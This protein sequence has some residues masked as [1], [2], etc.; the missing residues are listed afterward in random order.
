MRKSL[1]HL[2]QAGSDATVIPSRFEPCGLTQLCAMRY[3]SVPVV[4][5]VGGLADTIID[6]NE[7]A[8]QSG[9]ATGIQFAPVAA[10]ALAGALRRCSAFFAQKALWRRLQT[11]G[12]RTDVSW[13]HPA[14]RYAQIYREIAP[15]DS[16]APPIGQVASRRQSGQQ[17]GASGRAAEAPLLTALALLPGS[18]EPLGLTL[19]DDGANI[20]V[21]SE[22][23]GKNRTLPVRRDRRVRDRAADL[24]RA[25]GSG[26]SWFRSRPSGRR[27]L[28]LAGA[29]TLAPRARAFVSTPTSCCSTPMRWLSTDRSSCTTRCS[30]CAGR[31]RLA[32]R[33]RALRAEGRGDQ[34]ADRAARAAENS[35]VADH[36][37]TNCMCAALPAASQSLPED[38]ARDLRRSGPSRRVAHLKLSRRDDARNHALRGLD[39]RAAFACGGS[40]PIIGVIIP[41]R[42][43][44]PIHV[45]RP[46]A[47]ARCAIASPLCRPPASR[48]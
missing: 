47:G 11:N 43:W 12:L 8:L 36:S 23:G 29:R 6:A 10:E 18:P 26:L 41:L 48:C 37:S 1:A 28:W 14:C 42:L 34:P 31:L 22:G 35:V 5:R 24:T 7:M 30:G 9:C 25:D 4:A 17:S 21:Y 38:G 15:A 44:R 33:Q 27:A 45:L 32:R 13:A 20:A 19:T 46:A 2:I 39:R 40:D 16:A 3:G